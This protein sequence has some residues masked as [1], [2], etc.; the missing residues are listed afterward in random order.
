MTPITIHEG[1]RF[2]FEGPPFAKRGFSIEWEKACECRGVPAVANDF[3]ITIGADD[4]PAGKV[5]K[6]TATFE[7]GPVCCGCRK[8]WKL[9]GTT[10][11]K[12]RVSS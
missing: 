3:R 10:K 8:R 11:T 1:N 9:L 6:A 7:P 12:P 4:V 2:S 5:I